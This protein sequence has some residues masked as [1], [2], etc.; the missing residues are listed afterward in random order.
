MPF[1][2][3][4]KIENEDFYRFDVPGNGDCFFHCLSLELHGR[5]LNYTVETIFDVLLNLK[6]RFAT[7]FSTTGLLLKGM[8]MH[9]IIHLLPSQLT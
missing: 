4:I 5:V 9:A 6:T 2:D 7:M 3:T 1:E 8:R